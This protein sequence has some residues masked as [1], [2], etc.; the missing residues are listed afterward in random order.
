MS[1]TKSILCTLPE[2]FVSPLIGKKEALKFRFTFRDSLRE[3]IAQEDPSLQCQILWVG[4]KEK[5]TTDFLGNLPQ[6]ETVITSTTGTT[7]I[8]VEGLNARG[9]ALLSL[10]DKTRELNE[11]TA[12]PE[13]AWGLFIAAHRKIIVTDRRKHRTSSYRDLYFA[14]QISSQRVG[15]VGFGRI[16][17]KISSYAT[18]FGATTYYYDSKVKVESTKA[19]MRPLEWLVENCDALF[20][21]ASKEN[22]N[23]TPILG[24]DLVFR[25][26]KESVLINIARGSLVDEKAILECLQLG[27][28]RGYATDVLQL[29]E[30]VANSSITE[31]DL[32][33]AVSRGLN[34]IVTP[35]IGG[36]SDE[37]L[38][39][40]NRLMLDQLSKREL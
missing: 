7:H 25:L 12:T 15:I 1:Q 23:N 5:L 31:D 19:R 27:R 34:L 26:R 35:H 4:L 10:K 14:S 39:A 30:V 28:I 37:A 17:Q 11:V 40:V 22:E 13:L 16:G 32:E 33:W 2:R 20:I 38:L 6:L 9:I 8:D 36:A 3:S 29:E 24:R 18:S 21:C